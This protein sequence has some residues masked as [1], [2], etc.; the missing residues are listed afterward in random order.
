VDK[1]YNLKPNK[2]LGQNFLSDKRVL[3]DIVSSA[4]V[5]ENDTVIEI[6]PGLGGLTEELVKS[7]KKVIAIEKDKDLVGFLKKK[8]S[9]LKNLDIIEGDIRERISIFELKNLNYQNLDETILILKDEK[10]K[11]VAN[12]PYY[13]SSFILRRFLEI[14][15]KPQRIVLLLQKELTERI[16]AGPGKMSL[17]SVMVNF[18]GSPKM[19]SIVKREKFDPAPKV[20]SRILIVEKIK[21]PKNINEKIFFR[22]LRIGFSQKRK[23][24][25]N[26]LHNG[27]RIDKNILLKAI[28]ELKLKE[29]V[30]AQELS[31]PDW[32]DLYQKICEITR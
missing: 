17:V 29:T 2:T 16:C 13:L 18:Y 11:L 15:N 1:K 32:K 23:K 20:D 28:K 21:T 26:N 22:I 30:R 5:S 31:L 24:L 8:F 27:L 14:E 12:I 3:R 6:G 7:A 4:E 25:I 9:G 10:Y 19:G